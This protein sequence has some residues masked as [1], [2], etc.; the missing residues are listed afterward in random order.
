MIISFIAPVP[1]KGDKLEKETFMI[2]LKM[3][4]Q[5]T[6]KVIDNQSNQLCHSFLLVRL[7]PLAKCSD[8][9]VKIY[10]SVA[11]QIRRIIDYQFYSPRSPEGGQAG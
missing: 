9:N 2:T 3:L 11:T 6:T 4:L 5:K 8:T 7:A 1:P 10:Q